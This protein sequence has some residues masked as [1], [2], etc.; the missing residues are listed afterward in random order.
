MPTKIETMSP[1]SYERYRLYNLEY[2]RRHGADQDR[3]R[4]AHLR[5]V[6][7]SYKITVGCADCGYDD[8]YRALQFDH[9]VPHG[10]GRDRKGGVHRQRRWAE[11][12]RF[13][14]DSNIVV[15]CANC[16]AIK[17]AVERGEK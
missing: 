16:H 5:R 7:A 15:R 13:L 17:S 8:D 2:R 9:D 4:T 11:L 12:W 14:F 6:K 1:D 10:L 3:K